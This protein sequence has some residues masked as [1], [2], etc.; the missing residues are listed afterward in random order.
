MILCARPRFETRCNHSRSSLLLLATTPPCPNAICF[1]SLF[2]LYL[3]NLF[4]LMSTALRLAAQATIPNLYRCGSVG[5]FMWLE[6]KLK[7]TLKWVLFMLTATFG[8]DYV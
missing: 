3:H 7:Y 5:V 1:K 8:T 6:I 4:G 2:P